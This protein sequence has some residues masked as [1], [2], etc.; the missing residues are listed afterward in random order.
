ME[1]N[2]LITSYNELTEGL[3]GEVILFMLEILP[4]LDNSEI[5]LEN[6]K[7]DISTINY[8]SIFP[9]ILQ[10][11]SEYI[12]PTK[13]EKK[14]KLTNFRLIKPQYALG[15]DMVKINRLFFKYFTIPIEFENIANS[16]NLSNY[17]GIHFRG[18]DK[19]LDRFLN[20][21]ITK[22]EFYIIID[23]YINVNNIQNIFLATD[24]HNVLEYFKTKY[25]NINFLSSRDF[26]GN[27]YWKG[28]NNVFKN[29]KDAMIDMLCLS[30]CNA[31]LKVSSA[32]SSFSKVINPDLKIYKLNSTKMFADIPYFP[33]AYI[34][35]LEKNEKY[36]NEC[37]L[38][39]DKIQK[40]DWSYTHKDRFNNFF[41]KVR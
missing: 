19:T 33:D 15:D 32:L 26:T 12:N 34:P 20:E 13:I 36:S 35:L 2:I 21:P 17:L 27:L 3:F 38:L 22:E 8:G 18:T 7:W 16:Y 41:Y 10:Y 1:K 39:L 40:Y 28:N 29:A 6:I 14:M 4:I 25:K 37:N 23:S 5:K 30:K 24:E 9:N 31:V 11:N